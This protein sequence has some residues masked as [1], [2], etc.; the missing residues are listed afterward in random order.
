MF[1][2]EV[3]KSRK[4]NAKR[5]PVVSTKPSADDF[6]KFYRTL[7]SHDD[8]PSNASHDKIAS[9]VKDFAKSTESENCSLSFSKEM[10]DEALDFL[11]PGKAAGY[12]GFSNEFFVM[13][14]YI[15]DLISVK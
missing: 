7:F 5:A 12:G 9:E 2:K 8:R 11:K 1:W 15:I 4:L 6:V 3:K 13:G 10:I 14:L